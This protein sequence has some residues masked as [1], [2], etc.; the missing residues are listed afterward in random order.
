MYANGQGVGQDYQE[1][2][3][4]YRLAADQG[5]ADARNSLGWMYDSAQGV[6]R[7]YQEAVKWYRLAAHQ[8][9]ADAQ[10]TLG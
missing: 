6:A 9:N 10:N 2:L 4:W 1:V 8:G 3:K 7:D 5:N